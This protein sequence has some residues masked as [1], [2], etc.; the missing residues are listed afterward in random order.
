MKTIFTLFLTLAFLNG[1]LG[2]TSAPAS[3]FATA[4]DSIL[5]D[6]P[7][8]LRH[9][10][11]DLLLAQG[12]YENYSSTVVLPGAVDC[13]ITR[14]HS[15]GDTTASWQ[16]NMYSG[17]DFSAAQRCYKQLFQ[18]LKH[19][20]LRLQDSSLAYLKGDLE[21]AK[22]DAAFT[23][24][25]LRLG[26]GDW[27]YRTVQ[28]DVELVYLLADWAVRINIISKPPDDAPTADASIR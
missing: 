9:I 28:V 10:S 19:C 5:R 21:P 26:I 14:W 17:G 22:E 20:Y 6:F 15:T 11:G 8:N 13:I 27:R 2:Q 1:L 12:E 4:I 3:P 25:T 16:A 24:S 7:Q 23:T 18:Q